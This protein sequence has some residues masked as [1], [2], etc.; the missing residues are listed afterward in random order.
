[1]LLLKQEKT[2]IPEEIHEQCKNEISY[3]CSFISSGF[4]NY[5]FEG[6]SMWRGEQEKCNTAS[7]GK[8]QR[9]N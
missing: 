3:F 8:I 1:M 6:F 7:Q 4:P 5:R 9:A 2:L